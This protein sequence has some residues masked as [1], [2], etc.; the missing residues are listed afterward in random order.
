[1]NNPLVDILATLTIMLA[2]IAG[3]YLFLT[4]EA[5]KILQ[6][7]GGEDKGQKHEKLSD[8]KMKAKTFEST[9][10]RTE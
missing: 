4:F 7:K 6:H 8:G 3:G 10:K 2:L 1:M 9:K 5:D